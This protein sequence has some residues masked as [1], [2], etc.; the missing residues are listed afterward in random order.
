MSQ[1]IDVVW[2][3]GLTGVSLGLP[4]DPAQ[5]Q[6]PNEDVKKLRDI[7]QLFEEVGSGAF[8][9]VQKAIHRA[10]G[11]TCVV[12]NVNKNTVGKPYLAN[13]V[14]QDMFSRLLYM[15]REAPHVNV[16]KYLDFVMGP[17]SVHVVMEVLQGVELFDH[18][19]AS[20]PVT[21]DFCK[22]VMRQL[23][24]ALSHVHRIGIIHR[25]VKIE[26]LRYRDC[27]A[28]SDLVLFDFG[29]C[30]FADPADQH[31]IRV[32]TAAYM[33]P[34]AFSHTYD[35]RVDV[36]SAGVILFIL[37]A[38]QLPFCH[39]PSPAGESEARLALQALFDLGLPSCAVSLL[40]EML[41]IDPVQRSTSERA[42]Q[43]GWL[44]TEAATDDMNQLPT[45]SSSYQ[46]A[47]RSC[48]QSTI[49]NLKGAP[50]GSPPSTYCHRWDAFAGSTEALQED[51]QQ[52]HPWPTEQSRP[53]W[54]DASTEV[55]REELQ[56]EGL[57]AQARPAQLPAPAWLGAATEVLREELQHE[58]LPLL[59]GPVPV[60][61]PM[62]NSA[63]DETEPEPAQAAGCSDAA[64]DDNP[65]RGLFS[66]TFNI[67][68]RQ[69]ESR[70]TTAVSNCFEI[71]FDGVSI[72]FRIHATAQQTHQRRNGRCFR[73]A[74]GHGTLE[75]KCE[76]SDTKLPCV[77]FSLRVGVDKEEQPS[78]GP[79]EHDFS[80]SSIGR[81]PADLETWDLLAA[82]SLGASGCPVTLVVE[83]F[84]W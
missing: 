28:S 51:L 52:G 81:L 71:P 32:G 11:M 35:K 33:A 31:R 54:L 68:S 66:F 39:G 4:A 34:E 76:S 82:V 22:N 40:Q 14:E 48:G 73:K 3:R 21:E 42:L 84:K 72:P 18:L 8:G 7:Y 43:H 5:A 29:H 62:P 47:M 27:H 44:T 19:S 10:T 60:Q 56:R 46:A 20:A 24:S 57:P 53:T 23:L 41:V 16:I 80:Q 59:V 30:C 36:W 45:P 50:K 78:R 12:K 63:N 25:D 69:L 75:L 26:A 38:G 74:K 67:P 79:I 77:V 83:S 65:N 64:D 61:G 2:S 70:N 55:L 1:N 17:T 15:S 13:H 49:F 9:F 37:L 6:N 58:V